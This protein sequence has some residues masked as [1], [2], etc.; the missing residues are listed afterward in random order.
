MTYQETV[1]SNRPD[2]LAERR[3]RYEARQAENA[4]NKYGEIN[5][6]LPR[7][8]ADV[9]NVAKGGWNSFDKYKFRSID[10]IYKALQP[11]LTKHGVCVAPSVLSME[12]KERATKSGGTQL[13]T[14]LWLRLRWMAPDGSYVSTDLFGEGMDRGDKSI[15]KA[16]SAAMK[17]LAIVTLQIPVDEPVDSEHDS[18]EIGKVSAAPKQRITEKQRLQDEARATFKS[19]WPG[20][21]ADQDAAL[22]AIF[23][24]NVSPK[25]AVAD[26]TAKELK[27]YIKRMHALHEAQESAAALADEEPPR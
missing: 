6:L 21:G 26:A 27:E 19:L 2:D 22:D 24:E 1:E 25:V 3:K 18:P 4:Q 11:A 12:Q 17:Y 13:H 10:D 8:M 16:I 7:V 20:T 5:K 15:N 23:G 14:I 9:G